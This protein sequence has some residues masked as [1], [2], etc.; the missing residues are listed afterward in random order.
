MRVFDMEDKISSL[1]ES[2][3]HTFGIGLFDC[4]REEI[5][6]EAMTKRDKKKETNEKTKIAIEK[7]TQVQKNIDILKAKM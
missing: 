2:F 5:S 3:K 6:K 7:M 1:I 4:C